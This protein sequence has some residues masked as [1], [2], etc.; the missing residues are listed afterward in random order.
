M[1]TRASEIEQFNDWSTQW[2]DERKTIDADKVLKLWQQPMPRGWER[3]LWEG[4]LGYRKCT[5]E[6]GERR[7]EKELFNDKSKGFQ[8]TFSDQETNADYRIE[9]IYHNMPLANQRKGQVIAD[10]FGV[11]ET[12]K[13][14]DLYSSR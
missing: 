7:T 2:K 8:L 1:M 3:E 5:D 14:F 12:A 9:T 6:R 10:A 11:L 4:K 13:V